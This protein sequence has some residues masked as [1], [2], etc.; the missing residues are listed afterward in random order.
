MRFDYSKIAFAVI[1]AA[2]IV[3]LFIQHAET[4]VIIPPPFPGA[5]DL[6]TATV[7]GTDKVLIGDVDDDNELKTVTAQSIADLGGGGG[8]GGSALDSR[9]ATNSVNMGGYNI[10]N[11]TNLQFAG[12]VGTQGTL[13]WN[14]DEDTLDL[15]EGD[16]VLQLGQELHIHARN[17]TG[18]TISNGTIVAF[19]GTIGASSRIKVSPFLAD[20][21]TDIHRIVGVATHDIS[22][23]ADGK[24]THFGKVRNL[25]TSAYASGAELY[26]S[27]TS[28]GAFVTNAPSS[29]GQ[30]VVIAFVVNS[31]ASVGSIEV[32]PNWS[33]ENAYTVDTDTA[34][35]NRTATNSVN[36]GSFNI[37]NVGTVDGRDLGSDGSKLDGIESLA[38]ADQSDAEIESAYN[39]Q[40]DQVSAGEV[41]AG[42][43]TAIRRFSPK[44]VA[45]IA[46]A[47]GGG[48]GSTPPRE[49][50]L[51]AIG[52]PP[53]GGVSGSEAMA[54]QTVFATNS[55]SIVTLNFDDDATEIIGPYYLAMPNNIDT[56]TN[57]SVT[58]YSWGDASGDVTVALGYEIGGLSDPTWVTNTLTVTTNYADFGQN[59]FTFDINPA[60][61][62]H[63]R[64]FIKRAADH[65]GDTSAGD[66]NLVNTLIEVPRE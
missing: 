7:S 25:D 24:I 38:T 30:A 53:Y 28:A 43:E 27:S 50:N 4:Q 42:T 5:G 57:F 41:T 22:D 32:L 2:F 9:T 65:Y 21:N 29:P 64:W 31:H 13:S 45:D 59:T 36:M 19:A 35:D 61:R 14:A 66:W 16:A 58:Y 34:L 8:G 3:L 6:P 11:V 26:A 39:A 46:A 44:D 48:G 49:Y 62:E 54:E 63:T 12:G 52:A 37:T 1:P 17:D 56:G 55:L 40:V 20:G 23:G 47:H 51:P 60:D 18:S 33:D 15:V 10:S